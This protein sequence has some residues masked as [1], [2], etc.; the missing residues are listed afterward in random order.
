VV[1]PVSSV[2]SGRPM[3]LVLAHFGHWYVSLLYVGPVAVIAGVLSVQA[4]RDRRR[5]GGEEQ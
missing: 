1:G 4:W 5:G 2:D 3:T